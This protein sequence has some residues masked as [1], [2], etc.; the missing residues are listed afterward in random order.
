MN[1]TTII[2]RTKDAA[3][4]RIPRELQQPINGGCECYYCKANPDITPKWDTL[5]VP[6]TRPRKGN[7]YVSHVHMPEPHKFIQAMRLKNNLAA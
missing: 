1:G 5:L 4:I 3:Y 2:A 7:D 6:T